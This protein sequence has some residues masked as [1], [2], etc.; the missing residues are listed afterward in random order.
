MSVIV[1]GRVPHHRLAERVVRLDGHVSR[2]VLGSNLTL[3]NREAQGIV[4]IS[5]WQDEGQIVAVYCSSSGGL[6]FH[7]G[8]ADRGG[9]PTHFPVTLS[10]GATLR[11][12][13]KPASV[14][15]SRISLLMYACL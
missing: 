2:R 15:H 6:R 14:L 11:Y 7:G 3:L 1:G 5:A 8:V 12:S 9:S 4:T 13:R 10:L